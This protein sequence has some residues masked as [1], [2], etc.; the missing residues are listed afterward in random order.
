MSDART[1]YRAALQDF[2]SGRIDE[3]LAGYREAIALDAK[4]APAWNGLSKALERKGD[5]DGALDAA[6]K[7]IELEPDDALSHTNLSQLYQR[8]GM[9]PE[10]EEEKAIA[11][12]LSMQRRDAPRKP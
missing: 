8:K 12:R 10:A 1:L 5:L 7:L 4:L 11:M 6:R 2:V 3:A 9:I